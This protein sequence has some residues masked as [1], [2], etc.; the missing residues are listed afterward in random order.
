MSPPPRSG[1]ESPPGSLSTNW[2]RVGRRS[3]SHPPALRASARRTVVGRGEREG[4]DQH[5]EGISRTPAPGGRV[6]DQVLEAVAAARAGRRGHGRPGPAAAH[7]F[8]DYFV[9]C[10]GQNA[11]QIKAI[12]DTVQVSLEKL[13]AKPAH[14]EGYDRADGSCWTTSTSSCTCSTGRRARSTRSNGCG[15]VPSGWICPVTSDRPARPDDH[16]DRTGR[17]EPRDAGAAR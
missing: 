7:G 13:H 4:S 6:P 15:A 14:V 16:E 3:H 10:S 11:R 12:A 8:T 1:D 17:A 2:S 9:I 5:E